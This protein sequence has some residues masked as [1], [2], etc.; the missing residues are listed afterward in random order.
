M[1]DYASARLK[2]EGPSE[3]I[4]GGVARVIVSASNPKIRGYSLVVVRAS[5]VAVF[6]P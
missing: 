6:G 3:V 5:S 2:D 1:H 4:S